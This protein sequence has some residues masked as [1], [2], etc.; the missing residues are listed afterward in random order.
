MTSYYREI[1][2]LLHT[3]VDMTENTTLGNYVDFSDHDVDLLE[4][5]VDLSDI[6]LT[7]LWQLG[8]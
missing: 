4:N 2:I 8:T 5:Y 1:E 6:K 3:Q 7:S